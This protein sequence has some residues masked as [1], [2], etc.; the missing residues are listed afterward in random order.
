MALAVGKQRE[1]QAC[2]SET[3]SPVPS[4]K[5]VS[6]TYGYDTELPGSRSEK[7]AVELSRSLLESIKTCRDETSV[8][9]LNAVAN[10]F[11]LTNR[12]Q[13]HRPLILIG[14]SLGGIVVKHAL[15]QASEGSLD[16]Q[17]VFTSCFAVL[18][19]GVPNRGIDNKSLMAMVKGQPNEAIVRELSVGSRILSELHPQFN[20]T[21]TMDDT[22][23]ISWYETKE[24]ATIEVCT[25]YLLYYHRPITDVKI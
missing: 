7:L 14:H 24:T 11:S 2:G 9:Y 18:L 8:K 12:L 1:S 16:D 3:S 5:L 17:A 19:F 4:P 6:W 22:T 15:V 10:F 25:L 20:K 13:K 23:I 21:V